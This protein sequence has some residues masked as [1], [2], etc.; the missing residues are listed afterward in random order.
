VCQ[1]KAKKGEHGIIEGNVQEEGIDH[2][3]NLVA[4]KK[5][6]KKKKKNKKKTQKRKKKKKTKEHSL[7]ERRTEVVDFCFTVVLPG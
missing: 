1:S 2:R 5:K 3:G 4:Q 7:G 6:K